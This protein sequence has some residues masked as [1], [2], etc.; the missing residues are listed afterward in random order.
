MGTP[1]DNIFGRLLQ[2][3]MN[4]QTNG[5]TLA[6]ALMILLHAHLH[7]LWEKI[8]FVKLETMTSMCHGM[9]Y[10]ILTLCGMEKIVRLGTH[11]VPSIPLHGSTSNCHNPLLMTLR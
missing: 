2:G 1:Q 6:L 11:A 10:F 9:G 4:K 7:H 3:R 5:H 8:I